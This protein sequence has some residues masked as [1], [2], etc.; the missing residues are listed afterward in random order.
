MG[1]CTVN[2]ANLLNPNPQGMN[3]SRLSE[4]HLTI[5][6]DAVFVEPS[7]V[8]IFPE[9]E[10]ENTPSRLLTCFPSSHLPSQ[11]SLL[12][13]CRAAG[14]QIGCGRSRGGGPPDV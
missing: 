13:V 3:E 7:L 5:R 6:H 12:E 14:Q 1:S 9:G 8:S 10:R 2:A 11:G 4:S